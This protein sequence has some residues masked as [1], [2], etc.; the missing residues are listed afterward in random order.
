MNDSFSVNL[1]R[2]LNTKSMFARQMK[3]VALK[4]LEAISNL[5]ALNTRGWRAGNPDN[6]A[7][8]KSNKDCETFHTR[9]CSKM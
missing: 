2:D 7:I 1:F 8:D 4:R 5:F 9:M 6:L 3:E